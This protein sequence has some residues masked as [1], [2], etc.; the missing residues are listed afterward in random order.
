[1]LVNHDAE[2]TVNTYPGWGS[3][4]L[5]PENNEATEPNFLSMIQAHSTKKQVNTPRQILFASLV[6]TI[7]KENA[8]DLEIL[9]E[10]CETIVKP[11]QEGLWPEFY[12]AGRDLLGGG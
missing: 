8:N 11:R 12:R 3:D 9:R 4:S 1:M 6:G 10:Y 7:V 5:Y 2:D